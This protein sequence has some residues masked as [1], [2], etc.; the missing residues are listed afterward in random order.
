MRITRATRLWLLGKMSEVSQQTGAEGAP[1][2]VKIRLWSP[3]VLTSGA[4]R[5][6]SVFVVVSPQ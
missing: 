1:L 3:V 2:V 5:S 4:A 6:L